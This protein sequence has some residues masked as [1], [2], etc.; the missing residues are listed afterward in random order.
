MAASLL[1]KLQESLQK[2]V[3]SQDSSK[4]E[5]HVGCTW[6]REGGAGGLPPPVLPP[7]LSQVAPLWPT[8][9]FRL[10][11][12]PAS[13]LV[14]R[15]SCYYLSLCYWPCGTESDFEYRLILS[16]RTLFLPPGRHLP[17]LPGIFSARTLPS[18]HSCDIPIF[19]QG[20]KYV[21]Y[22]TSGPHSFLAAKS[23]NGH[24]ILSGNAWPQ[25]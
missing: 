20:G 10:L 5:A 11:L 25:L 3:Q 12:F 2:S 18:L 6:S 8:F 1:L 24:H 16:K 23:L 15:H 22:V 21:A 9:E 4:C 19:P 17:E 14:T 13:Q 7:T